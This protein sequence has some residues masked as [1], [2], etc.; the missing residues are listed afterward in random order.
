MKTAKLFL[1]TCL[2]SLVSLSCASGGL[3]LKPKESDIRLGTRNYHF[4]NELVGLDFYFIKSDEELM[5]A[6]QTSIFID[7]RT[8]F[9]MTVALSREN[10][11]MVVAER[12]SPFGQGVV[13]IVLPYEEWL[14]MTIRADKIYFTKIKLER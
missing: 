8:G 2:L 3:V 6:D 12:V 4:A 7:N 13:S 5:V 1:I 11:K 9:W 10:K 14:Y